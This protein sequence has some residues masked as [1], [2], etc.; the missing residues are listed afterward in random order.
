MK[1]SSKRPKLPVLILLVLI[2]V[3]LNACTTGSKHGAKAEDMIGTATTKSDH[4]AIADH[5]Q[6][7]AEEALNKAEQMRKHIEAY[8]SGKM[9][10]IPRQKEIFVRHCKAMLKKYNEIAQDNEALAKLHREMAGG[11]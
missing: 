10:T 11:L 5:Y 4:E 6:Q 2:A 9:Q 7:E 8:E 3:G 1:N